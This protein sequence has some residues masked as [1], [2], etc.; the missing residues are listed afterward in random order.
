MNGGVPIARILGIEIR[1]SIAWVVLVA[2]ITVV[3][4]QQAAI[5]SPTVDPIVQWAV[6][7]VVAMLFFVSILVHELAHALV[8]RRAG[9]PTTVIALGFV[10]GLAP[11]SIQA[12]RARD[13]LVVALVGPAVSLV[14]GGLLVL[15]GTLLGL[16]V[17]AAAPL[18]GGIVVVGVLDLILGAISL[19]PAMP[20]DGGRVVRALAWARTGDRD[21][22]YRTTARVGRLVGWVVIGLGIALA[23]VD[24]VTEGLICIAL[25]WLLTS[26]ASTVDRRLGL[27][28]LLRGISVEDAMLRDVPF[29]GPNLTID[30]FADRFDGPDAVVAMPVVDDE[31]VVGVLGR[32]RLVRLG[33]RRFGGTRVDEV[34]SSPPLVP[35]LARSDALW[36]A[37]ELLHERGLDALAVAD[38]GRLAGL[39][40]REGLA[41]AI[42]T[43]AAAR[44]TTGR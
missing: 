26:S 4:A 27:E 8:G 2:L 31:M 21:R 11:L 38:G 6:G 3:G 28:Q 37:V 36:D 30:T 39:V 34:M 19:L 41:D 7:V 1:V 15:V 44:A 17:P 12:P 23:M 40:T 20:L 16:T 33:R 5:G 14:V 35:V 25:G 43:R 32:R 18:A 13:E 22:A 29:V 42:R 10:G 24:F 9:V